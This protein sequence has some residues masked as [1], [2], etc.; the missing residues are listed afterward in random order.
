MRAALTIGTVLAVLVATDAGA[1]APAP[2]PS[3]GG[4]TTTSHAMT[5][6][7]PIPDAS[8]VS[9]T[10]E[11]TGAARSL[12]DVDLFVDIPHPYSGDLEVTLRSPAGTTALMVADI[13]RRL[14]DVFAD[15]TFDDQAGRAVSDY[16]LDRVVTAVTPMKPLSVFR[17]EDPN[18]TWTLTVVDDEAQD[19]GT[20]E[21][22]RLD[23]QALPAT[24]PT[25]A[26]S[27]AGTPAAIADVSTVTA[28]AEV[29]GAGAYLTDLDLFTD[30]R[31]SFPRDL[32]VTLTSPAGTTT[33]ITTDNSR[34]DDAF[35]GTTFDDESGQPIATF[36]FVANGVVTPL[37]PEQPLAAFQGE[38]PTGTWTLTV[39]DDQAEDVGTLESWRLDVRT[40]A[41][42]PPPNAAEAAP[43]TAEAAEATAPEL[44]VR[45]RRLTVLGSGAGVRCV[46]AGPC[47]VALRARG[48]VIARGEA[49][50][51]RLTD[52]G[53]RLLERRFGGIRAKVVATDGTNRATARTR[54]I[55]A[56]EHVTTPP[57]SWRAD[58][59]EPTDAGRRFLHRL[60]ARMFGVSSLRCD[61]HTA[62]PEG[63]PDPALAEQISLA[64]A[65]RV[66]GGGATLVAH[67]SSDPVADE[68]EANRRVEVTVR[69]RR[70]RLR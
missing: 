1:T 41:C 5:T 53:R 8:T 48:H 54:A 25:T 46:A 23:I 63:A 61:G 69:H 50:A 38:N 29:A 34:F 30:L 55:L 66:C 31:H 43:A 28:T 15:T 2:P 10:I 22:W 9:S 65:E 45:A 51:L 62:A 44:R 33:T 49:G 58:T 37:A 35:A 64:R 6:P 3:C 26:T 70:A 16:P 14:P 56:V 68:P 57:G 67:G 13:E 4:A 59:A 36:P 18:G 11:V 52:Y 60:R 27:H 19:V 47:Q 42:P 32:D 40:G 21:S 24:P 17:G 39:V 20:L 12:T 7:V